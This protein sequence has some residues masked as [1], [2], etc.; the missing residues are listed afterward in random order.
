M[1]KQSDVSG[2][3]CSWSVPSGR[4]IGKQIIPAADQTL[5]QSAAVW[6]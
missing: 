3:R 4:G 1:K 2:R 5:A 6:W